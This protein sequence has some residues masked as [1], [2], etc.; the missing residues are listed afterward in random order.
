LLKDDG[1]GDAH[2]FD[3]PIGRDGL[4]LARLAGIQP[5]QGDPG[6]G[7]CFANGLRRRLERECLPVHMDGKLSGRAIGDGQRAVQRC[8]RRWGKVIF[9]V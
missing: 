3:V 9:C 2:D 8:F 5:E 6:F 7:Q 4:G 1:F